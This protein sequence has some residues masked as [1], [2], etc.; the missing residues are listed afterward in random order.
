M[1][2]GPRFVEGFRRIVLARPAEEGDCANE[3]G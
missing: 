3:D 2:Q 1:G